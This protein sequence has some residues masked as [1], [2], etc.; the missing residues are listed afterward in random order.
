MKR[1]G[2]SIQVVCAIEAADSLDCRMSRLNDVLAVQQPFAYGAR[3][4][5]GTSVERCRPA[6][7]PSISQ[8]SPP[9]YIWLM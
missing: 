6:S 3:H 2:C 1:P 4:A 5:A 8:R 9:V 7:E